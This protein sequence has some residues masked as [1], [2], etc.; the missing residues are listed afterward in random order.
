[1]KRNFRFWVISVVLFLVGGGLRFSAGAASLPWLPSR[2]QGKSQD[3]VITRELPPEAVQQVLDFY[4]AVDK[5]RY[6]EA[7]QISL[8]N[9]WQVGETPTVDRLTHED[10]FVAA[11]DKEL[12]AKGMGLNI[13][14]IQPVTQTV[15]LRSEIDS[16][17]YPELAVL[18]VLPAGAKAAEL[19]RVQL[20]G[21]LLGRCSRWNW[22]R[23]VLVVNLPGQGWRVLLP[24][25]RKAFRPHNADWFLLHQ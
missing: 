17:V 2:D 5:G 22:E 20:T 10:E 24:G 1:M 16:A 21:T 8:E 4:R 3:T 23:D 12:G 7:F 14:A 15:V 9:H 25:V 13:V 6:V 11:L 19:G 18:D